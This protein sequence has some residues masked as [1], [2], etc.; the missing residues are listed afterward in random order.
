M[1]KLS[2]LRS[3][4]TAARSD[5]ATPDLDASSPARPSM[6]AK[7]SQPGAGAARP[8]HGERPE[9]RR[10]TAPQRTHSTNS[11]VRHHLSATKHAD[12]DIDIA[13]AF[14]DVTRLP[15]R[16]RAISTRPRPATI[17]RSRIEDERDALEMSKY[18]VEPSPDAWDIGQELEGEQTFLRPGLRS[19]I[20]VKLRRGHWAV[21]GVIDLHRMTVDEAHDAVADFLLEAR[22]RG[23]RCVRIIHGKG[24]TSPNREPV[25]KGKVRRWLSQWDDVLAYC[26]APPHAGGS[27]AV[28]ALLR[29]R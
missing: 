18:G 20:L 9:H 14:A 19:D 10:S 24:L 12:G 11:A 26:E 13:K 7:H 28:I 4:L 2:D 15:P 29:G 16:N 6:P 3:L 22:G 23:A 27:G 5:D 21:Q 25:L 8:T 17:P 1:A